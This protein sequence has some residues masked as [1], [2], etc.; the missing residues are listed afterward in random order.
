MTA[1]DLSGPPA[2]AGLGPALAMQGA[3]GEDAL[4][5]SPVGAAGARRPLDLIA[6]VRQILTGENNAAQRL[7]GIVF[8][9]R[10]V[11]A[12]V[13]FG[14]QIVLARWMGDY[15]FGIYVG[16]WTW[17]L[18][19][20]DTVHLGMPLIAQRFIPDYTH[21]NRWAE[22]R[23][24]LIGSRWITFGLATAFATLGAA[25]VMAASPWLDPHAVLPFYLACAA[26]PFY[27]LAL[28]CDALARSNNWMVLA[29]APH[30]LLRP[31]LLIALLA[32]GHGAGYP[33]DATTTM[34]ALAVATWASALLQLTL[35][36]RRLAATVPA[37]PRRYE[38]GRWFAVALP[39][40]V[41]WSLY[42]MLCYA[43]VLVLQQF[44][45]AEE[46]AHYYAAVKTLMLVGIIHFSI[47]A[48]SGHRFTALHVAGERGALA[49][50]VA[51][52]IRWTFWPSLAATI[53][54]LA[55]GQPLLR[56]FG[57]DFGAGYPFMLILAVGVMARA[58]VGPAERL[59][60]MLGE[61][62]ICAAIYAAAFALNAGACFALAPRFG[63]LGTAV[64]TSA[65][66]VLE[67]TLLS[68]AANRRLGI[69]MFAWRG[70]R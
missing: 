62:R 33:I 63:G 54:M 41:V 32:A 55:V 67:S 52:S 51:Q 46:V 64:A 25:A 6:V 37:G 1:L 34:L 65:A 50:F 5:A 7:A 66:I 19:A 59:L 42:T 10:V 53:V 15:D 9:I 20:G 38:V 43:D 17:L 39:I 14:S 44:R 16:V 68:L 21:R 61:Q 2:D 18:L 35:V 31:L 8:A 4:P 40:V 23:G 24:F 13:T 36:D 26:L 30:S 45:P 22:L 58:A 70:R 60:N 49:D 48:A 56:L 57:P 3:A 28:M 27:S 12:A 29:L 47:S 69:H 11:S